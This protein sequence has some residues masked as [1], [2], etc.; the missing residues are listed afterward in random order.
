MPDDVGSL[1]PAQKASDALAALRTP[2][3]ERSRLLRIAAAVVGLAVL[4]FAGHWALVGRHMVRTDNAYVRADISL[5]AA[6][7][8]GYVRAIPVAENAQVQAGDLLLEID[9]AD[10][11]VALQAARARLAQAE[12]EL[13]SMRASA[14]AAAGRSGA[15]GDQVRQAASNLEAA[16]AEAA[17][18]QS[19]LARQQRLADEG[20]VS[21]TRLET[22]EAQARRARADA[23]AARA[24]LAYQREQGGV[25]SASRQQASG[26]VAA[27][28]AAVAAA[29]A[30][31][32]AAELNLSRTR[33]T[34]PIAGA[35]ANRTAQVGQ[36]VRP[37]AQL[38]AIVPPAIYVEANFKETQIARM[39][40]GQSV[41]LVPDI[42][43]SARVHGVIESLSPAT[44]AEF[45]FIP[46]ETATGNFTKIV[47]RIPV[48]VRVDLTE[49]ARAILRP[50]LS[51][52]ATVDTRA[53]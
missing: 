49:E 45:A 31:V 15:Q 36:L 29:R 21:P 24:A 32:E 2:S 39:R 12:A 5:V 44:G 37:G 9:P 6:Q 13:S 1:R 3:P 25:F 19:E 46:V 41:T 52:T 16:D 23:E 30:D 10:Y 34:A 4:A 47:Q 43:K 11:A 33:V 7:V 40:P 27:A 53:P 51:V 20:F 35:V 17:R 38:L 28:E 22:M 48:R 26:D 8:E 14:R 42:D 50:G 18:A